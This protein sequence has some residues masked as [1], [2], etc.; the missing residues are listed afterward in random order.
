MEVFDSPFG[1]IELTDERKYHILTFHPEVRGVWQ[2]I[3]ETLA[4][5]A[6][7]RRSKY[8]SNVL[9]VYGT[10]SKN[11][12]LA[13][14]IKRNARNFILTAYVTRSIKHLPL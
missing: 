14:V 5:P 4:R 11:L 9:I 6:A 10:I 8:D 12:S 1:P 2:R 7:T 3:P 13:V